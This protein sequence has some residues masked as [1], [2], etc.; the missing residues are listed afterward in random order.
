M[1]GGMDGSLLSVGNQQYLYI[2]LLNIV[3]LP[4][5]WIC[6]EFL[7][8]RR[9]FEALYEFTYLPLCQSSLNIQSLCHH[10]MYT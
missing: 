2:S 9:P 6:S 4:G 5:N 8:I 7:S 1:H 3:F 10:V